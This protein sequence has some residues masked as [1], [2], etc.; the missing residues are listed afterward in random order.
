MSD[1]WQS[2]EDRILELLADQAS[3][4]L[5]G[6]DDSDLRTLMAAVPDFDP[7]CMQRTAATVL[8]A[9]V[10]ENPETLPTSLQQKI[11]AGA[12][13]SRWISRDIRG[14]P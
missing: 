2:C 11:R 4:G 7:D 1:H 5:S 3:F 6:D 10:G 8:L 9:G 12:F 13:H 14:D